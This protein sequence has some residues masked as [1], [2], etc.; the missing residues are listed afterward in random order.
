MLLRMLLSLLAC[1]DLAGTWTGTAQVLGE[2]EVWTFAE[3]DSEG[4]VTRLG[5]AVQPEAL[6]GLPAVATEVVLPLPEDLALAPFDHVELG[7]L[8]AGHDP[9]GVWDEPHFDVHFF[10][11]DAEARELID[12]DDPR[13]VEEP[14][15]DT[16]PEGYVIAP[17]SAVQGQGSHWFDPGSEEWSGG[18]FS[19]SL[20]FGSWDSTWVFMEP[21]ITWASLEAASE[22]SEA[23]PEPERWQTE[24][25]YPTWWGLAVTDQALEVELGGLQDD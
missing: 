24:G 11:I 13:V 8:P 1:A 19:G 18:D 15:A 3:T 22:M 9:L 14:P 21:M 17:G 20:V 23:V 10:L 7:W 6:Q 12:I 2:G 4:A 25:R 5:V 16:V